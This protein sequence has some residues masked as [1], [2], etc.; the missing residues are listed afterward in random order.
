MYFTILP[1][2]FTAFVTRELCRNVFSKP[3]RVP[4][5]ALNSV[6]PARSTKRIE[7]LRSSFA[8]A[9][10][11]FR[12]SWYSELVSLV[13][14]IEFLRSTPLLRLAPH[15]RFVF[16]RQPVALRDLR[17]WQE[18]DSRDISEARC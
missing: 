7:A 9:F 17:G 1:R 10:E 14:M 15:D 13:S 8:I 16:T 2:L 12:M 18:S 4:N 11:R 5:A 3:R 6:D